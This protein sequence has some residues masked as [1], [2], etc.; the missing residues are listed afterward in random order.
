[1]KVP[2]VARCQANGNAKDV[3]IERRMGAPANGRWGGRAKNSARR[4]CCCCLR[5]SAPVLSR[6]CGF[7]FL[8][9]HTPSRPFALSPFRPLRASLSWFT[10][11][12][13][14]SGHGSLVP[15]YGSSSDSGNA[16]RYRSASRMPLFNS[17]TRLTGTSSDPRRNPAAD[18]RD[19]SSARL[20]AGCHV[21]RIMLLS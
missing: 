20:S 12:G 1:M 18:P 21:G 14:I 16:T 6:C 2:R 8:S 19:R 13:C 9:T 4:W 10:C 7:A 5:C 15:S 3:K 11:N 17:L